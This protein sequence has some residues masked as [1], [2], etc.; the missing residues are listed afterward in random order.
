MIKDRVVI[1]LATYNGERYVKEQVESIQNQDFKD[2]TLIVRDDGST[3]KTVSC[4]TELAALDKRITMLNDQLGNLGVVKN[5]NQLIESALQYKADYVFFADQD[6]IWKPSKV[7]KQLA[8]M[9]NLENKSS[10][11]PILIH[12]N[13]EVVN[14]K[15]DRI[16]SSFMTYQGIQHEDMNPMEVLMV[17]NFVTGCTVLVNRQLLVFAYPIPKSALMHDW[18]L[19]LCSVAIG[20]LM[21]MPEALTLYRQH[22]RNTVGAKSFLGMFLKMNWWVG[23]QEGAR[24]LYKVIRQSE[25]LINRLRMFDYRYSLEKLTTLEKFVQLI[26]VSLWQKLNILREVLI[27]RQTFIGTLFLYIHIIFL[28]KR[29][30]D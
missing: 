13:L 25:C 12:T 15:L 29:K 6:D 21:Y 18:W 20:K 28:R 30:L 17:Q 19:A 3:D 23:W 5:F 7:S 24:F 11:A 9:K 22:E 1:L 26:R 16:H 2:W 8:F 4:I 10:N 14:S 27:H